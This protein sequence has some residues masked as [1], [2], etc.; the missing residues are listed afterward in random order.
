MSMDHEG[1]R[2]EISCIVCYDIPEDTAHETVCCRRILCPK[3][4]ARL[5][6]CPYCQIRLE[7]II[8]T[9]LIRIVK[10]WELI[11]E[12]LR[13]EFLNDF[14]RRMLSRKLAEL[15]HQYDQIKNQLR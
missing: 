2:G 5:S 13:M 6:N 11:N 7:T 3:C 1:G 10:D 4:L 9:Q 8:Q 15:S 12:R 14:Q